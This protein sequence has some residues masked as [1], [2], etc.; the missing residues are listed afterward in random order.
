[1]Q[2]NTHKQHILRQRGFTVI[3][4]LI[5]IVVI[6]IIASISL[7]A[8]SG[9]Q[10]RAKYAREQ[11]DLSEVNKL[12][13][14]YYV[15]NGEYPTTTSTWSGLSQTSDYIPGIVPEFTAQIPQM[16]TSS[17]SEN[18]FIYKSNGDDY[19]LIC[20]SGSDG[21]PATE[22]VNNPLA[23]PQRNVASNGGAW[24]YWTSGAVAW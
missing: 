13:H 20:Y 4:L 2:N 8:Y 15:N 23:D 22:R 12:I 11:T 5:I 3:E 24:G 14:L 9:V 16:P 1:M 6:G 17:V 18:S 10:E 21:L 7:V 19:K